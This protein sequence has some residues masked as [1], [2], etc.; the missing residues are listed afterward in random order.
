MT[1][2]DFLDRAGFFIAAVVIFL[3]LTAALMKLR[4]GW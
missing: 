2:Y 1:E 3:G 4:G